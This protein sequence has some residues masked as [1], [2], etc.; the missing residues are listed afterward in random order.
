MFKIFFISEMK[1]FKGLNVFD[2]HFAVPTRNTA[3]T[4]VLNNI[5]RGV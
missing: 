3:K 5:N 2:P 4:L 1:A